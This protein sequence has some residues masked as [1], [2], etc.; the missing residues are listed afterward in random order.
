MLTQIR[1]GPGAALLL[2]SVLAVLAPAASATQ[3][4]PA[5]PSASAG[6]EAA[7]AGMAAIGADLALQAL[8]LVGVPYLF[9]GEDPARGFDC[10]GLVRHV[11]RV[12]LGLDLP[13]SSEAIARVGQSVRRD[14]LQGGDLVFFNTRGQR[15]SHVGV[16]IGDGRFV[17][18]PARNGVVRVEALDDRYWRTRFTGARRVH[19]GAATATATGDRGLPAPPATELPADAAEPIGS[20]PSGG[21]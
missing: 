8:S 3:A 14:A 16:Y 15:N 4:T 10:S 12:V 5:P 18:A 17:H 20:S 1:G 11:A 9:G 2:S 6:A 19:A 7:P 13:R 21:A